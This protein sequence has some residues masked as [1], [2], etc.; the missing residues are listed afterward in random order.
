MG[1]EKLSPKFGLKGKPRSQAPPPSFKDLAL[2]PPLVY[3]LVPNLRM[4][5]MAPWAGATSI[6]AL[7]LLQVLP[8]P[9]HHRGH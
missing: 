3:S 1:Q 5:G 7:R 4:P 2:Q 6:L 8:P 9:P